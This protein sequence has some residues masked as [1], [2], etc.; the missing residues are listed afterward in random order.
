MTTEN[1]DDINSAPNNKRRVAPACDVFD[2]LTAH[3]AQYVSAITIS[4]VQNDIEA[5]FGVRLDRGAISSRLRNIA[6]KGLIQRAADGRGWWLFSERTMRALGKSP[7]AE[8][9]VAGQRRS[10]LKPP[11]GK[12][13]RVGKPFGE[14]GLER[15]L[16]EAFIRA[17]KK[18]GC[19][20]VL[21]KDS[22]A[23]YLR[24]NGQHAV[25]KK[26][27]RKIAK[28]LSNMRDHNCGL[29]KTDRPG[30]YCVPAHENRFNA[31]AAPRPDVAV[32]KNASRQRAVQ[33]SQAP[34]LR[35]LMRAAADSCAAV[36]QALVVLSDLIGTFKE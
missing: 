22:V 29:V 23:D 12:Q 4:K 34:E 3:A 10:L 5:T 6:A 35:K 28:A 36:Q 32:P 21:T 27:L 24:L 20:F 31:S 19:A 26:Q 9:P 7:G 11:R 25:S 18:A 2:M 13:N 16:V 14:K 8:Q 15:E 30:V 17:N 33:K 1:D